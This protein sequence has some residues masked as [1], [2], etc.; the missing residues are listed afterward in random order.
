MNT[1][2]VIWGIA[3]P[4]KPFED[5]SQMSVLEEGGVKDR[6]MQDFKKRWRNRIDYIIV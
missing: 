6:G 4:K 2:L 5:Y 3:G 1:I